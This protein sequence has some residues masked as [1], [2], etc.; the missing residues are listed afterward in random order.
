MKKISTAY[1]MLGI[2]KRNFR[3]LDTESFIQFYCVVQNHC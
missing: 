1:A 2:I 3:S